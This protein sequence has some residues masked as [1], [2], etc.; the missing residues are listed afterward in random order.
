MERALVH[1]PSDMRYSLESNTFYAFI[2][3]VAG[4]SRFLIYHIEGEGLTLTRVGEIGEKNKVS[5]MMFGL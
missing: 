1:V 2:S 4:E 3:D 5:S